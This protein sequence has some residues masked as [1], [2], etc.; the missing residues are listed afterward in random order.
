ME[1]VVTGGMFAV[2]AVYLEGGQGEGEANR[3]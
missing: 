3:S 2:K 1:S